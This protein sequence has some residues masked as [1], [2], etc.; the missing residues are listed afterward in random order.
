MK[1]V[2]NKTQEQLV[3]TH[4]RFK[5]SITGV[6]AATL[7]KVRSLPRRIATLRQRGFYIE[8]ERHVDMTGQRYV[9][10][11]YRG[12]APRQLPLF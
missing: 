1:A 8:S 6:E 4:L 10:Y 7:Y 9:R 3:E 12:K 5:G 2:M 11:Q